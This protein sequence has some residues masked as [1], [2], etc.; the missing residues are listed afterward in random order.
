MSK[1]YLLFLA[2]T[3]V[4][5]CT[6]TTTVSSSS[7]AVHHDNRHHHT[8]TI[9]KAQSATSTSTSASASAS[10]AAATSKAAASVENVATSGTVATSNS[11]VQLAPQPNDPVPGGA[12]IYHANGTNLDMIDF[13]YWRQEVR[14][15]SDKGQAYKSRFMKVEAGTYTAVWTDEKHSNIDVTF[16]NGGGLG[17]TLD[18]RGVTI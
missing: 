10:L 2:L 3:V 16:W 4:L 13:F 8:K 9:H 12:A 17:W 7:K 5:A 1:L 11:G 15:K 14:D 18:L 6:D